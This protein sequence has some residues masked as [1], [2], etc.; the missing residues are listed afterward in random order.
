MALISTLGVPVDGNATTTIMPKL[1]YRF[2]VTFI[3]ENFDSQPTR[4]V[5]AVGRPALQHD[6]IQID[7]YNS[8]IYLAG[9]HSWAPVSVTFR[10][11]VDGVIITQ[12]NKQM[13]RQMDHANQSG[14]R[15]GSGYK[16]GLLVETL[17]GGNPNPG[18]LD[19][20]ELAGCYI[21]QVGY[22]DLNYGS[23]DQVTISMTVQYDNCEIYDSAGN[24]TL[25]GVRQTQGTSNASGAGQ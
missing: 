24:P 1:S 7:A 13:N 21:T 22:G 25:T 11:D 17:D 20:Y 9:K 6:P 16:F 3:G 5:I 4:S 15:A 14:V 18:V 12:I 19:T 10:D 8:R 2:R 23:S